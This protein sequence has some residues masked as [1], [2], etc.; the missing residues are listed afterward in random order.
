MDNKVACFDD[1]IPINLYMHGAVLPVFISDL[2]TCVR[3]LVNGG[4]RK[5]RSRRRVECGVR[6]GVVGRH[7]RDDDDM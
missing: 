4:S 1:C 6:A 7:Q 2:H 5:S 3:S